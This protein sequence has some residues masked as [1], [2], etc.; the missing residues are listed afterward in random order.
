[1]IRHSTVG[2]IQIHLLNR[3]FADCFIDAGNIQDQT[4][5]SS[6]GP[7]NQDVTADLNNHDA[8]PT[9]DDTTHLFVEDDEEDGLDDNP[10]ATNTLIRNIIS[11]TIHHGQTRDEEEADKQAEI[12]L[13]LLEQ[14]KKELY[15]GCKNATKVS[16]IVELFQIKCMY[17][18]SNAS[19][20]AILKLFGKVLPDR[21]CIPDSLDKVQRVIRDL[22][23]DYVKIHACQ[24]DC[25]LFFDKYANLETCPICK[26]SRWKVVD[27]TSDNN[28]SAVG[29]TSV[30]KRLPVKILR[31]F[32]LIPR[33]QRMYMSKQMSKDM[34]W[35]KNELVNDGK[36]RHPA[37]S[38]A[39]KHVDSEF[40]WF[41][42]GGGRNVRLGL[43]SDGFNP[44]GMQSLT[45]S[46]WPVILVPYNLPPWMC[47]KQSNWILSML[48]PGPKS[49]GMDIDVYLRPL[50]LELKELWNNGVKT[51]DAGTKK[52]FRLRAILLW[53]IN[54]FPAYAMLSGWSTKGKFACP[55]CHKHTEY[56][57]L[58]H[59]RKHCYMAHRR[60]L[61][62]D[63]PWRNNAVSFNNK[64]ET[65][66]APEPLSGAQVLE[67]YSTFEQVEFGKTLLSKKGSVT[68]TTDGTTGGRRVFFLSSLTGL[69][70]SSGIIWT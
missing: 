42:E 54:D 39:W 4:N 30:K 29:A 35:H 11:G 31:Y 20:E 15:P 34:Q 47:Q 3:G 68:K 36:M 63:H 61:A 32:P 21:H 25:V 51:R 70:C 5:T 65:R 40:K 56:L 1:M 26:E 58:K 44:F 7:V 46:I 52:N 12:F 57:W 18:L 16:F 48:I 24:N 33:L 19:L 6:Q 69:L 50:I 43:A 55:Y 37:D 22:G 67:Q 60:F 53:T 66:E 62:P 49:P 17:G 41:S 28:C 59:G 10:A 2:R 64:V 8:L 14:A 38:K 45:Y 23:L 27:K 9:A 13:K